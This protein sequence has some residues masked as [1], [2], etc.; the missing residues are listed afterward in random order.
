VVSAADPLRLK[1]T[2][3]R[4]KR[5]CVDNIKMDLIE[6]GWC[7]VDWICPTQ[8]RG[9]WRAVVKSVMKLRVP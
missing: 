6:I 9:K 2:T 3:R 5:G 1:E 4:T 8:D 7:D